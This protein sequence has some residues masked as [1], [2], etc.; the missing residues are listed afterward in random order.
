M[1]YLAVI[2]LY[3]AVVLAFSVSLSIQRRRFSWLFQLPLIF[4]IVHLSAG[5]GI[6]WE[7]LVGPARPLEEPNPQPIER[8][9]SWRPI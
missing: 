3:A 5:V 1:V 7:L 8:I 6:C 9:S 4:A 2:T